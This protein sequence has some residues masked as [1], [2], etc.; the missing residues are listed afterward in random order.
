MRAA[1]VEGLEKAA[2]EADVAI[3]RAAVNLMVGV[4]MDGSKIGH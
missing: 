1:G 4:V 2:A 3:T